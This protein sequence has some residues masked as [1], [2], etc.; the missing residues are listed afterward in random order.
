MIKVIGKILLV[1]LVGTLVAIVLASGFV[2]LLGITN[3][4]L[5]FAIGLFAGA[6]CVS[7]PLIIFADWI[8]GD[9]F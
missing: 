6:L 1:G 8:I 5:S 3:I 7:V 9:A 4:L 2:Y